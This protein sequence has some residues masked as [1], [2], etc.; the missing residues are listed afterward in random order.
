MGKGIT[1]GSKYDYLVR[2]IRKLPPGEAYV[3]ERNDSFTC[4]PESFR[5]ILYQ[6]ASTAGKGWH[7][8]A[9]IIGDCVVWA[10]WK[11]GDLM[12]PNLL[13][14]PIVKKLRG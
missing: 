1:P 6:A 2:G 11:H 4:Q 10:F 13:A 12:R 9:T 14:Y 5:N 8:S 7:V 3:A